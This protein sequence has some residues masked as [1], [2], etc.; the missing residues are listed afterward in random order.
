MLSC[1]WCNAVED[2][3]LGFSTVELEV[4]AE[5]VTIHKQNRLTMI[6]TNFFMESKATKKRNAMPGIINRLEP[7]VGII[8]DG[9]VVCTGEGTVQRVRMLTLQASFA[10]REKSGHRVI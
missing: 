3:F 1:V 5:E 7:W 8:C 2:T 4:L 9:M 6:Q 10:C